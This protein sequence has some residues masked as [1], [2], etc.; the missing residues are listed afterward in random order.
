MF[1]SFEEIAD[2]YEVQKI[3]KQNR[4]IC[5]QIEATKQRIKEYAEKDALIKKMREEIKL[6]NPKALENARRV[7][8][9]CLKN[10]VAAHERKI[11]AEDSENNREYLEATK[12]LVQDYF[13]DKNDFAKMAAIVE[14][15]VDIYIDS[16]QGK[17]A[18]LLQN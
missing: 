7:L 17:V 4:M 8:S 9:M 1:E 3:I 14:E 16:D 6:E 2:D 5:Y 10:T 11:L 18:S 12:D 13:D 15:T